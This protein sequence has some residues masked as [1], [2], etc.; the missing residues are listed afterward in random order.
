ML[1]APRGITT[2]R[3]VHNR[4]PFHFRETH[5]EAQGP[6]ASTEP[7][8]ASCG[9]SQALLPIPDR[10]LIHRYPLVRAVPH[11]SL[12][13]GEVVRQVAEEPERGRQILLAPAD[14][15]LKRRN[16]LRKRC[17]RVLGK[18]LAMSGSSLLIIQDEE[19][20]LLISTR[21]AEG[22]PAGLLRDLHRGARPA[23]RVPSMQIS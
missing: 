1:A 5:R 11:H 4:A 2:R 6:N 19:A 10:L 21:P 20:P 9:T 8:D 17:H 22:V 18:P 16:S 13:A 12:R 3:N 7:P 14:L 23:V 15:L